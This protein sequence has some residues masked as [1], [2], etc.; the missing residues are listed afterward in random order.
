MKKSAVVLLLV[1]LCVAVSS[2]AYAQYGR[3]GQVSPPPQHA[4]YGQMYL[5]G[6]AGFFSPNDDDPTYSG[7]GLGGYDT[8][9]SFDLGVGS[10]VSSILAIEG[11]WGW[12][13][14]DGGPDEVQVM[15]LTFGL[16]LIIPNPIIEPYIG[17]GVGMYF[18]DIDEP[19]LHESDTTFGGYMSV[20]LD[21]WL[22]P[23]L[24]LNLEGKY[25]FAEPDFNG[26]EV[27]VS[28]WT[29]GMGLRFVF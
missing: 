26:I 4:Q 9:A 19:G 22:N 20:G 23:R 3:Q 17:A 6:H 21:A 28:G 24:A 27:D 7:G 15:P 11:A 25:H 29:F 8:G 1:F 13:Y 5:F 2:T 10:R 12:M 14:A 18:A 16:R